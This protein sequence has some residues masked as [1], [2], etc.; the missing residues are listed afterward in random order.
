MRPVS[1]CML[2]LM[3]G[4]VYVQYARAKRRVAELEGEVERLE[5]ELAMARARLGELP[6]LAGEIASSV[7]VNSGDAQAAAQ[8]T[9]ERWLS[10]PVGTRV[11]A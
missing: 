3:G 7:L 1:R 9:L 10:E 11:T 2:A 6:W 8:K 4:G 5:S